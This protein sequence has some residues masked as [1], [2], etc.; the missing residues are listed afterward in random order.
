MSF[1]PPF[2]EEL[3]TS[4]PG[5]QATRVS[6]PG[7]TS[8][9]AVEAKT[10]GRRSTW[11]GSSRPGRT[12]VGWDE[13]ATVRLGDE[14]P[15]G[16]RDVP[17]QPLDVLCVGVSAHHHAA[18]AVASPGFDDELLEVGQDLLA[19]GVPAEVVGRHRLDQGSSRR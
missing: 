7:S 19:V 3:T 6:P 16:P 13:M 17:P 1:A 11:R 18:A 14:S 2:C 10:N 4:A 9:P 15:R 8:V 12:T 5:S